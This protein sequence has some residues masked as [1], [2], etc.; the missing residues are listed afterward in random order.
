MTVWITT[1]GKDGWVRVSRWRLILA[2]LSRKDVRL[3]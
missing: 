2:A 1:R 3:G